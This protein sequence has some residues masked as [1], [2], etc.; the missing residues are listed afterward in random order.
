MA[1]TQN[2]E[3]KESWRDEYLRWVCG[4]ANA[5][6][7][8]IYIGIKDNG[9]VVGVANSKKL[10]E[11]IPN[12]IRNT[13][14]ILADVNLLQKDGKEY[15]EINVNPSSY[16]VNYQGEYHIRSG[17]TK[18]HLSGHALT[19]FLMEKTGYKW[20]AV[21][22]EGITVN[23]LDRESF[24][25]FRREAVRNGR[26]TKED[27]NINDIELLD[28]LDLLVTGKLK[29]AAVMLFHRKPGR[30]AAGSY[31]KIGR[32]GEGADLQ[33]QDTVEGSLFYIADKVI[34]LIYT[35][36]LKATISYQHDVRVETY[37]FPREAVR[38]AI[39][40]A[41]GH[42]NYADGVPI[43]VRIE[44]DAMYIS[45]SCVLP[46]DWT[47]DTLLQ[48]HKSVPYNPS[49]ANAFY[50]AGYIE[51]WGRGIQK[52]IEA[53]RALGTPDPNYTILGNDLTV[54]L[55]A[56]LN[57]KESSLKVPKYHDDTLDDTLENALYKQILMLLEKNNRLTQEEI[58][59]QTGSSI[60]TIKRAMKQLTDDG[61]IT[62]EGGKR[63]GCWKVNQLKES[64]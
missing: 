20:D 59:L 35:K 53:C 24:E 15:I 21:P 3:Y 49:I 32:F 7:G 39:Y 63:Y 60:A 46:K 31:I 6:G 16:P 43:Q 22:V 36:Y 30:I 51:A 18:Q 17:S 34:D 37:P 38:E 42:N 52:M 27:L 19:A 57:A 55:Y 45:N 50:R 29:R 11:D 33:Y 47:L 13:M 25:I 56:H 12:K 26:M 64:D 41:L 2:I 48:K 28:H 4:F 1:E 44:D 61:R 62:R 40:N 8:R 58:S 5:Q 54:K 23:D 14:G 10:M 9:Q